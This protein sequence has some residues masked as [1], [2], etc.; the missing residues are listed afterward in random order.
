MPFRKRLDK[1]MLV[2]LCSVHALPPFP[3]GLSNSL[4]P[5]ELKNL[6]S[7][8]LTQQQQACVSNGE[9][10]ASQFGEDL[11]LL[12]YLHA[13]SSGAAGRFVEIGAFDGLTFSNTLM[14]EKCLG[15]NG[16]LIEANP[17]NAAKLLESNRSNSKFETKA[18]CSG[19]GYVNFTMG[20]GAVAGET[21]TM[22]TIHDAL[23]GNRPGYEMTVQVPCREM[24]SM[25]DDAK[26]PSQT[27]ALT[28]LS[29]DVE[30]A[31]PKVCASPRASVSG[32]GGAWIRPRA[33][34][35][36]LP[37]QPSLANVV[38]MSSRAHV[39]VPVASIAHR[40][41]APSTLRGSR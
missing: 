32:G 28:F 10:N 30:G 15:W 25:M 19:T 8:I 17:E 2:L 35:P 41:C 11:T 14:L 16:L 5:E 6:I 34:R 39:H 21:D 23:F 20:G 38:S 27:D 12:P 1:T 3:D 4:S 36:G 26:L 31:E 33:Q 7:P 40:Y 29:L 13:I 9:H 18:V 37:C 24:G 22:S